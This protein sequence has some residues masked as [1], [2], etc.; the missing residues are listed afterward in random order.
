MQYGKFCIARQNNPMPFNFPWQAIKEPLEDITHKKFYRP[1]YQQ[2]VLKKEIDKG[3]MEIIV[4]GKI[5][6]FSLPAEPL[7]NYI[8]S[9]TEFTDED[10]RASFPKFSWN[11][12]KTLINCLIREGIIWT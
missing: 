7:L 1:S 11:S 3:F 5:L 4:W 10:L 2:V 6:K 12:I 9:V 8:F